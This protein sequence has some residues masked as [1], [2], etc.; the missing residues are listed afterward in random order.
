M[1]AFGWIALVVFAII[2]MAIVA[3]AVCEFFFV[4]LR[5]F[6]ASLAKKLEVMDEDIKANAELKKERLAKKRKAH[7]KF[8]NQKL[9]AQLEKKQ[10]IVNEKYTITHEE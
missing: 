1:E 9:D 4:Q 8:A 5:I 10:D 2:G 7:D 3:F 6:A